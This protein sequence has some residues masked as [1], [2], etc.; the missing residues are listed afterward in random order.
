LENPLN[1]VAEHLSRQARLNT[2]PLSEKEDFALKA[3]IDSIPAKE[4]K[5]F[6]TF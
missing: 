4:Y 5:K 2:E 1:D 3:K 6:R